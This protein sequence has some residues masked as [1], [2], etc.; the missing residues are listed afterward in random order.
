[1]NYYRTALCCLLFIFTQSQI[2]WSAETAR[3]SEEYRLRPGDAVEMTIIGAQELRVRSPI[4]FD[5]T[6]SLPLLGQAEAADLTLSELRAKVVQQVSSK[7]YRQRTPEGREIAHVLSPDDISLTVAEYRPIY[8]NGDVTRPGEQPFRPGM[9][10]RQAVA[11]AGGYDVMRFRMNNPILESADLKAEYQ[12]L[13]IEFA[14]I[15]AQTW[16]LRTELGE[17]VSPTP[18][19]DLPVSPETVQKFVGTEREQLK[20][21]KSDLDKEKSRLRDA[22][23][24]AKMQLRVLAEKKA[25]DEEGNQADNSDLER[26][27]Q[28]LEKGTTINVRISEARRAALMSSTQLL[29]TIVEIS[30]IER[31]QT[32]YARQL[33]RTD[34]QRRMS[35]LTELQEANLRIAQVTTRLQTV[36]E[37]LLYTSTLQSQLVRG[38]G[39]RPS[40]EV[41]RSGRNGRERIDADEETKLLPGDV[42]DITLH[43]DNYAGVPTR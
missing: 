21:R 15:Q 43:V 9:T 19:L 16:R 13:W 41:F 26:L 28:L 34:D 10:V 29:Q 12:S 36:S 37:K 40:F 33:E 23:D 32:E 1:M 2:S 25:K 22:I 30:N 4:A 8:L 20:V 27:R 35:V 14:R 5:G 38:S 6:I 7:I 31:Q 18:K 11:V 3:T 17:D 39:G 24:Q 42:V